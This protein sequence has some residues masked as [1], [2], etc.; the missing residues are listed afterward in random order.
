MLM[1]REI[2]GSCSDF[3]FAKITCKLVSALLNS[4]V[5]LASRCQD[6]RK[7]CPRLD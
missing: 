2:I 5:H 3:I 6:E 4:T 1:L 7:M